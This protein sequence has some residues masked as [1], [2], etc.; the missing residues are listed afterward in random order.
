MA[1]AMRMAVD[2]PPVSRMTVWTLGRTVSQAAKN[3]NRDPQLWRAFSERA[4]EVAPEMQPADMSAVLFGFARMRY[5]DREL[6]DRIVE[7]LP[8]VL[9]L[10]DANTLSFFLASFSRV[11]VRN[12]FVL[13]LCG[14]EVARHAP[15]FS[16]KAL[17]HVLCT[18]AALSVSP[19]AALT[20]VLCQR[21]AE[22]APRAEPW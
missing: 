16:P 22:V 9:G 13:A 6:I 4:Q 12:D 19:P 18:Y 14:R 17:T 5:R 3:Q 1:G 11:E 20:Q 7:E 2:V 15:T 10:F 21:L 8:K